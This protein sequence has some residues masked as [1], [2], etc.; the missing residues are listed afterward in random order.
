MAEIQRINGE[1][2]KDHRGSLLFFNQ[3]DMREIVRFY[4]IF[5]SDPKL[6]RGWQGHRTEKKWFYCTKGSFII[7]TVLIDNFDK[8]SKSLVTSKYI[9]NDTFPEVLLVPQGHATAIRAMEKNARLQVYSNFT[10][11]ESKNDDY[12]FDLE[13]WPADWKT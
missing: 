13:E 11:E 8:P 2:F 4:E 7:N 12:R 3:L 5:P 10:L 6:I 9:L 1:Y